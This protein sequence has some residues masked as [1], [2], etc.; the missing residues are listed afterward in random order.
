MLFLQAESMAAHSS[1]ASGF[2]QAESK[3]TAL[4]NPLAE[5]MVLLQSE[6]S[7]LRSDLQMLMSLPGMLAG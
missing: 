7:R 3:W 5:K 2:E 4:L 6:Q 1:N